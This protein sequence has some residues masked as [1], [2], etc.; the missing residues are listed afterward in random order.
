MKRTTFVT[1]KER[2][3]LSNGILPTRLRYARKSTEQEDRQVTSIAQQIQ[4]MDTRWGVLDEVWCWHDS[5]SG[6]TLDR[7]GLNDL[8][9]F[10][11]KNPRPK[12]S[13]GRIEIYDVS[14]LGRPLR[15]DGKADVAAL[16]VLREEFERSNW[17]VAF[18]DE[19]PTG[20]PLIDTFFLV[21]RTFSAA[22]YSQQISCNVRRGKRQRAASGLWTHGQP[23][24][25]A[26]RVEV[27]TGRVIPQGGKATPGC[28]GLMLAAHPDQIQTWTD[29]AKLVIEGKSLKRVCEVLFA[30]GVNATRGGRGR[31][32]GTVP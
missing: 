23:P 16:I 25:G 22:S 17:E 9:D 3:Q 6:T 19:K 4:A 14:R 5:Q 15:E 32:S 7:P 26:Q 21:I 8:R 11:N 12:G 31:A 2:L 20:D 27:S 1:W 18:F 28:G 13:P 29:A 10:C 24:F 30:S